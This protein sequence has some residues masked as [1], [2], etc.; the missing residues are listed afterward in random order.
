MITS[1]YMPTRIVS[2]SGALATL[3]T[4]ARDLTMSRVLV[5]SDPVISAQGFHADALA[6]LAEA[7]LAVSRFDECGIDARCSHID[8]QGERVRRDRIDGV[9]CIGGGSVMCTGKGI[10][11]VATNHKPMAECTGVG[12]FDRKA[13]PM[14]MVPTTAGSGS[15]VSQWTI[16]KD[17]VRHLKLLGGGPLSFP[18]AAILDPAT[19]RSLPM[20]VAAL[21]AVDALTHGVEAYLSGIA[22]PLTD[23]VALAAVRLQA[24]SLRASINSDDDRAREDNLVAS[25]MA[26]IACGNAR[27]GHGHALSLPLEGHLDLPH[28]YGVGVLLPHVVTFNLAVLP[29]KVRPLAEALEVETAGL[30][31]QEMIEACA[32]AIRALYA[33]IGFPTRFTPE[34]LPR[35]RVREMAQRA[36]PGLYAGIAAKDFDPASA[37]DRT[38]IACPSARKMTVRQAEEIF[39][40]CVG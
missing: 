28:P 21:P 9:V 29:A 16:V 12:Q 38:L 40:L 4:L 39:G 20:H 31:R 11:I 37:N 35:D 2:G 27:L 15:E 23:A 36:V 6:A 17:E 3:G 19:L 25:C 7:G 18:D 5:V 14:I 1:F 24:A 34:Q 32:D 26:N 22:S 13:L 33:D 8:D 10:A 30:S